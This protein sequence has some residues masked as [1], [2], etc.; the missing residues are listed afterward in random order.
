[1]CRLNIAGVCQQTL[2][3]KKFV[4]VTQQ[5]FAL[6]PQVKFPANNFNSHWRWWD[7]I[8]AFLNLSSFS[9]MDSFSKP[10][11]FA[12]IAKSDKQ[13]SGLSPLNPQILMVLWHPQHPCFL[14]WGFQCHDLWRCGCLWSGPIY[15][16]HPLCCSSLFYWSIF[17]FILNVGLRRTFICLGDNANRSERKNVHLLILDIYIN[18]LQKKYVVGKKEFS[19]VI[20]YVLLLKLNNGVTVA[21]N[22][23]CIP[24]FSLNF[25][26]LIYELFIPFS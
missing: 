1:M 25:L 5:C 9:A 8:Q 3:N 4:C 2:E 7:R 6:L 12:L 11:V 20:V 19:T 17:F 13:K 18:D 24:T 10:E 16:V 22:V 21:F 26:F 14:H 15:M 23:F